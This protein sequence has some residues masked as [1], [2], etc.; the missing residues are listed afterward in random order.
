MGG[1]LQSPDQQFVVVHIGKEP[2]KQTSHIPTAAP[3]DLKQ[4]CLVLCYAIPRD[5]DTKMWCIL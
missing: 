4:C 2:G 5:D 1:Q 3:T